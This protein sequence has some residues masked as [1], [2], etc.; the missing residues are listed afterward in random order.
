[1]VKATVLKPGDLEFSKEIEATVVALPPAF[2]GKA[3]TVKAKEGMYFSGVVAT[4]VGIDADFLDRYSATITWGDR[5]WDDYGAT[6]VA[7]GDG[8]VSVKADHVFAQS[9]V[10]DTT[11]TVTAKTTYTEKRQYVN[12]PT[13][14]PVLVV[15][16]DGKPVVINGKNITLTYVGDGDDYVPVD[17]PFVTS[18][19]TTSME[20]HGRV[21]V[22][23]GRLEGSIDGV[24]AKIFDVFKGVIA[25]FAGTGLGADLP[26]YTAEVDFGNGKILQGV[27]VKKG[28]ELRVK[29]TTVFV[30]SWTDVKVSIHDDRLEAGKDVV[31]FVTGGVNAESHLSVS[32]IGSCDI[33]SGTEFS[34]KVGEIVS[35]GSGTSFTSEF[36]VT[37]DWQD[38]TRSKGTLVA[39]GQG[40][41][42]I[43]G[44]HTYSAEDVGGTSRYIFLDVK[45]ACTLIN[46]IEGVGSLTF[47]AYAYSGDVFILKAD[48]NG[49]RLNDES[50]CDVKVGEETEFWIVDIV[51]GNSDFTMDTFSGTVTWEDGTTSQASV[52]EWYGDQNF[53]VLTT[54]T[55]D[56]AG[57]YKGT[58][59]LTSNG[60]TK[61]MQFDVRA[62]QP[63]PILKYLGYVQCEDLGAYAGEEF[64]GCVGVFTPSD[65]KFAISDYSVSIKWRDGTTSVGQLVQGTYGTYK[66][67][68]SHEFDRTGNF[69]V[70]VTISVSDANYSTS[71]SCFYMNV[72]PNLE[73]IQLNGFTDLSYL[74]REKF[75]AKVGH[76]VPGISDTN[77]KADDFVATIDWGD[78]TTS[79]GVIT[80]DHDGGFDVSG[81]HIYPVS[82]TKTITVTVEGPNG[83]ATAKSSIWLKENPV[84]VTQGTPEV[85][86][87]K[88]S[89]TLATFFDEKNANPDPELAY[90]DYSGLVEWGDGGMSAG[91]ISV[92]S[93]GTFNVTGGHAYLK[94]GEYTVEVSVRV[95]ERSTYSTYDSGGGGYSTINCLMSDEPTTKTYK[96]Q[97]K[98]RVGEMAGTTTI[99]TTTTKPTTNT[100][101]TTSTKPTGAK[102]S[103]NNKH[104]AKKKTKPNKAAKKTKFSIIEIARISNLM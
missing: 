62:Y 29:V 53:M 96:I 44:T 22:S 15:I 46:P 97:F 32:A 87:L 27:L 75:T 66:I 4:Y 70:W 81:T 49:F 2:S 82:G 103:Q 24:G 83:P 60:V 42:D 20:C 67:Y 51:A 88:V 50:W 84:V 8:T 12:P 36:D 93:N 23:P 55:F 37:I 78:G 71:S 25:R 74:Q 85:D 40:V 54:R 39:K 76:F 73:K 21:E 9:G 56:Q 34:G 6:L 104:T 33:Q 5:T 57:N 19:T 91:T 101:P 16:E 99:P 64:N 90:M 28:N 43:I 86:G 47:G 26:H 52:A 59:T 92:N 38:G 1:M 95:N 102:P 80:K 77:A 30:N 35:A 94:A 68:G 17:N 72:T 98:I 3:Y 100:K 11:V 65:S 58:L 89:G 69:W 41:Y 10:F 31:G 7:N 79:T 63:A 14:N 18:T 13:G 61:E 48:F 45:E